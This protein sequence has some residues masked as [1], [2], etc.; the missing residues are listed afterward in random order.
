[1][2]SREMIDKKEILIKRGGQG[3][4]EAEEQYRK[5]LRKT[6]EGIEYNINHSEKDDKNLRRIKD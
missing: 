2:A 3:E 1:M 6:E 5:K 4:Y